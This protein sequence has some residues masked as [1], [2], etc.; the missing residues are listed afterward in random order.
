[1]GG[2]RL[3]QR[4]VDLPRGRHRL[5]GILDHF[6]ARR[7][8]RQDLHI[9]AVGIHV[10]QPQFGQIVQPPEPLLFDRLR[11]G[12]ALTDRFLL[13]D[14]SGNGER[15]FHGHDA[16]LFLLLSVPT[17]LR[18]ADR[19]GGAAAG[20]C[21]G[22]QRGRPRDQA[23]DHG[24]SS[25]SGGR[26][27]ESSPGGLGG[28]SAGGVT[29]W[30]G[31]SSDMSTL[32]RWWRGWLSGRTNAWCAPRRCASFPPERSDG[33]PSRRHRI[34]LAG[35]ASAGC[36]RLAPSAGRLRRPGPRRYAISDPVPS[37][38]MT[39]LV[40]EWTPERAR[41]GSGR[42]RPSVDQCPSVDQSVF[43]PPSARIL[44]RTPVRAPAIAPAGLPKVVA[45]N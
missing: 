2:D 27:D 22:C 21:L 41:P 4:V 16:H 28:G 3:G 33:T 40:T 45:E 1:M 37:R 42:L 18:A 6:H 35:M 19:R 7:G 44:L 5:R 9:D 20:R 24:G 11:H 26:G 17:V 30:K 29:A 39:G 34:V 38:S 10:R 14:G 43:S 8:I 13:P 32:P 36:S 12:H 31:R 15:L 23:A 25:G